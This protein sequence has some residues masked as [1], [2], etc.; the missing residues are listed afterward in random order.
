MFFNNGAAGGFEPK[1]AFRFTV[2][3][4]AIADITF[5][6]KKVSKPSYTLEGTE[7][8]FLNHQ[9]NF[10][11]IVKWSEIEMSLIDAKDPNVGSELYNLL[12]NQGYMAP[13]SAANA[14]AGITKINAVN[15]LGQVIIRQLDG[16]SVSAPGSPGPGIVNAI[17]TWRLHN[18]FV[19]EV[20][21]GDLDY[22]S[23]D[24]I[25]VT[26]KMKFDWADYDGTVQELAD[27]PG[28]G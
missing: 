18:A 4:P 20:N 8:R 3:F 15:S 23:D 26:L 14:A 28:L 1:R 25:E 11:N 12:L 7:H 2:S 22:D 27:Q 9:F 13:T 19:T 5:M 21:W 24:L 10:P 6:A 17:E 16:G